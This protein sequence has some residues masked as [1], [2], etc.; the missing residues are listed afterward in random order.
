MG[1]PIAGILIRTWLVTK[2]LQQ[3]PVSREFRLRLKNAF[4]KHHIKLGIPQQQIWHKYTS[5]S[6]PMTPKTRG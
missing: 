6:L 2:P 1:F 3:F 5:D 4:D